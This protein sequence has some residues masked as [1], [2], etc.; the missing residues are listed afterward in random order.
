MLVAGAREVCAS[1]SWLMCLRDLSSC[2][3]SIVTV[4]ASTRQMSSRTWSEGR[5]VYF[6][7]FL[8]VARKEW[9]SAPL[10][11]AVGGK[12]AI[13]VPRRSIIS[14]KT[15]RVVAFVTIKMFTSA[16][17]GGPCDDELSRMGSPVVRC[18]SVVSAT[19]SG[20]VVFGA[21]STP[22]RLSGGMLLVC[23]QVAWL[24]HDRIVKMALS[25][26]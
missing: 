6:P 18:R 25:I 10:Q 23:R 9:V 12:A 16:G 20:V 14:L 15:S 3:R 8:D 19:M 7:N 1:H 17:H 5:Q 2:S 26:V 11:I 22:P 21:K 24:W 13:L 4:A